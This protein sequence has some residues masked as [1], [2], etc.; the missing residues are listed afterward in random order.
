[1]EKFSTPFRGRRVGMGRGVMGISRVWEHLKG[2]ALD[3]NLGLWGC[4][5][6]FF[7]S[8]VFSVRDFPRAEATCL[9]RR[10]C[11]RARTRDVAFRGN[12]SALFTERG[13]R[14]W[15]VLLGVAATTFQETSLQTDLS[16]LCL[17][18]VTPRVHW[19]VHPSPRLSTAGLYM[20]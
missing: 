15:L 19:K 8:L 3:A 5:L 18:V 14:A 2:T 6:T 17:R 12:C 11:F 10:T 20:Y 9:C 7:G 1:M 13:V 4:S 16:V